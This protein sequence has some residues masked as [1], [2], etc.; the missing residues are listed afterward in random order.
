MKNMQSIILQAI[1][2]RATEKAR[3]NAYQWEE[4]DFSIS[5]DLRKGV[6]DARV[7]FLGIDELEETQNSLA[8]SQSLLKK[9]LVTLEPVFNR[10]RSLPGSYGEWECSA[11]GIIEDEIKKLISTNYVP[12]ERELEQAKQELE[13]QSS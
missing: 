13:T 8:H 2:N 7:A 4:R 9:M 10:Y 3:Q 11:L 12:S 5:S 1:I 6:R